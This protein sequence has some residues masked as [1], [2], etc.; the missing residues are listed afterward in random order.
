MTRKG[1]IY[2][3]REVHQ[4]GTDNIIG[5]TD[6]RIHYRYSP[7]EPETGPTYACGGTPASGPEIELDRVERNNV[8]EWLPVSPDDDLYLWAET[9][10]E[11][12]PDE[13]V[14][15]VAA[16]EADARAYFAELKAD[17]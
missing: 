10:L 6:L 11:Q 5:S 2:A 1:F 3:T 17:R 13:V 16:D 7:G 12:H 4:L 9:Y 14:E 15:A 8:H